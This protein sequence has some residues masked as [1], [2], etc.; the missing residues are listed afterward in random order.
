MYDG[1]VVGPMSKEQV[2]AYNVNAQTQVCE[3]QD[4]QWR[5]LYTYPE[6]MEALN[7]KNGS[8]GAQSDNRKL[9]TALLAIFIG[10]LGIQYFYLGKTKAALLSILFSIIT[11]GI[12]GIIPF[13]QGI[14]IL[15][16][17]EEDFRRKFVDSPASSF[18]IF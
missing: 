4:G 5:A 12:W 11:C 3:G 10:S 6:L 16:M 1:Q 2:I 18:P 9:I 13:I 8:T 17:N 14:I 7:E 15:T